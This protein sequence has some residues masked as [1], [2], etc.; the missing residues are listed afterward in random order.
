[1]AD[2]TEADIRDMFST[3]MK[4]M[5]R[6]LDAMNKRAVELGNSGASSFDK[7]RRQNEALNESNKRTSNS[8]A[9]MST[10]LTGI[11]KT[12]I[13]PVGIV[14]G[15]AAF[16]KALEGVSESTIQLKNFSTNSGFATS[17]IQEMQ[18]AMRRMGL[19]TQEA[20]SSIATLGNKLNNL[21]AFKEGSDVFQALA[22]AVGGVEFANRILA[23]EKLGDRMGALNE[24]TKTFNAQTREGKILLSQVFDTQINV[25]EDLQRAKQR[26]IEIWPVSLEEARKYHDYWVDFEVKFGNIWRDISNHAIQGLNDISE[27]FKAQGTTTRG[28]ADWLNSQMDMTLSTIKSTI[29]EVKAIKAW[30]ENP[31]RGLPNLGESKED[32]G[33]QGEIGHKPPDAMGDDYARGGTLYGK[34]HEWMNERARRSDAGTE[35]THP[36]ITDFSGRRRD[37]EQIDLL[38][39]MSDTLHR[40][41]TKDGGGGEGRTYGTGARG[42]SLQAGLGGFRPNTGGV[43]SGGARVGGTGAGGF[44][45][46]VGGVGGGNVG[47][48]E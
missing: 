30:W 21:R 5:A 32:R 37:G 7:F 45:P 44:R 29:E 28:I 47:V 26:G 38:R 25:L 3:T 1:M 31:N 8:L 10:V 22:K 15:F 24:I 4:T 9:S 27:A 16:Q 11:G 13:G 40:M 48:Y 12:L 33:Y 18:Q 42:G 39:D 43:N 46:R 34:F 19:S 20:D 6:E 17:N 23:F 36:G 41:E 35:G 14:A 2:T